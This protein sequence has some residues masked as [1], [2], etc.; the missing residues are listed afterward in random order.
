MKKKSSN[1]TM[2]PTLEILNHIN[3]VDVP[4]QLYDNILAKINSKKNSTIKLSYVNTAAA[5]LL[6]LFS[7]EIYLFTKNVTTTTNT[8]ETLVSLPNNTLYHE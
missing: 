3:R 2:K 7:I 1:N 6:C 8:V 5:I 4:E